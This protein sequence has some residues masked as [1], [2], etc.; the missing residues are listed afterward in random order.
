MRISFNWLKDYVDIR[1][2]PEAV[3]EKLTMAGL[4]VTSLARIDQDAIMEIEVTPNRVDCLS[5]IGIAREVAAITGKKL[6]VHKSPSFRGRAQLTVP[7]HIQDKKRCLRYLGRVIKNVEIHPSPA[8]LIQ[9]LE[10]MGVRPVNNIVDITNFCLLE[11]GQPLHAFDLDKLQGRRIIVRAAQETE[12]IVTIDGVKRRLESSMLVIADK[13]YP[14]AIAGIMGAHSSEVSEATTNILLESAYFEP[15][16]IHNTSRK[17][18]LATQSSYRFERGV[19]PAGVEQGSLRAT[20]LIQK[21]CSAKKAKAR[22]AAIGCLIEKGAKKISQPAQVQLRYARV[23]RVLGVE[24]S[25]VQIRNILSSLQ[26]ALSRKS[27]EGLTV[28]I[29]SF[30]PDIS[31]EAD[32][33]EEIARLY[34]YDKISL[35]LPQLSF[36][37]NLR[38]PSGETYNAIRRI[39]SSLGLSEIMTYSLISRQ[40]LRNL[41]W[42]QDNVRTISNPLSYAQEIMRPTLLVGMLNTLLANINRKNM[43]LEFF[44]L[45]RIYRKQDTSERPGHSQAGGQSTEELTNLCIGIAGRK[46]DSWLRRGFEFTFFDLKGIVQTLLEKL[47]VEDCRFLETGA[48][49]LA[50]DGSGAAQAPEPPPYFS[51]GRCAAIALGKGNYGFIGEIKKEVLQR[52]DIPSP[53]YAA[54]LALQGLL[55]YI[56]RAKKFVPLARFP[57]IERDISL[58]APEEIRSEQITALISKLGRG[59]IAEVAL[60]DQYF[61]EQIPQGFRGLSFSIKY[62]SGER[63][64]TAEEVDSLHQHLRRALSTELKLQLR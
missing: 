10:V 55:P 35:N 25:P 18:G 26:F 38:L 6:K 64:L 34:G 57:A 56:R 61:G 48:G 51:L 24:I 5:V 28:R 12:E 14:Q 23:S 11:Y 20:E 53:V 62:R 15:L 58:I 4:E 7:I 33:T 50:Q 3:A 19:S 9:R 46:T 30:R 27:K 39:L 29:P 49:E 22:S 54:E 36:T 31:R 21:L 40:A 41:E 16:N 52:F 47:G 42:A 43:G 17:L 2:P 44:E 1:I 60:F 59:L 32:L 63:T 45:S 13:L 8:W 37:G